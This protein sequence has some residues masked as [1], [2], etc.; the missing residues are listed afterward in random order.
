M[1]YRVTPTDRGSSW[2]SLMA[3][4][5]FLL[6]RNLE[7]NGDAADVSVQSKYDRRPT[8]CEE[9]VNCRWNVSCIDPGMT[10][11][12]SAQMERWPGKPI[13][14]SVNPRLLARE[15]ASAWPTDHK[16]WAGGQTDGRSRS[17]RRAERKSVQVVGGRQPQPVLRPVRHLMI[18]PAVC[19]LCPVKYGL[20]RTSQEGASA[21]GRSRHRL[22]LRVSPA[23]RTSF[24]ERSSLV[25]R[26]LRKDD[27]VF[28]VR[29]TWT[30][31][32]SSSVSCDIKST[33]TACFYSVSFTGTETFSCSI[34]YLRI[35]KLGR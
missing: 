8:R 9:D 13:A 35:K 27:S 22:P 20:R 12:S 16:Y 5:V 17:W 31:V 2:Q 3:D 33:L 21:G 6:S 10:L 14:R 19:Q 11:R 30:G 32:V 29:L 7:A 24:N 25:G 15:L 34:G 1:K 28:L 18:W 4:N 26:E 23:E